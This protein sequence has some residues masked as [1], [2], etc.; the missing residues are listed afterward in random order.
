MNVKLRYEEIIKNLIE[1]EDNGLKM[2]ARKIIASTEAITQVTTVK[3]KD[4]NLMTLTKVDKD[5]ELVTLDSTKYIKKRSRSRLS[6]MTNSCQ[7]V[8]PTI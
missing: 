2:S 1:N 5:N 3:Q 6:N 4:S 8:D 7:K